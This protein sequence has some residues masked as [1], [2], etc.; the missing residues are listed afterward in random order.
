MLRGAFLIMQLASSCSEQALRHLNADARQ[1]PAIAVQPDQLVFSGVQLEQT[2]SDVLIIQNDGNATLSVRSLSL[3]GSVSFA[4]EGTAGLSIP[5]GSQHRLLVFY[6]ATADGERGQLLISSND[7]EA[8]EIQVPLTGNGAQPMLQFEPNPT[9]FPWS[10]PGMMSDAVVTLS[11]VGLAEL[12]VDALLVSGEGFT[13][14]GDLDLPQHLEPGGQLG[15]P[16]T[17]QAIEDGFAEGLISVES[18]AVPAFMT[19]VLVGRVASG[20]VLGQICT[21]DG[22]GWAVNARVYLPIDYNDDGMVDDEL[23]T[24][25]DQEGRFTLDHVPDGSHTLLV[26]KGSFT[27]SVPVTV[28]GT[29]ELK[30]PTCLDP[31][32]VSIAVVYGEYDQVQE[33]ITALGLPFDGYSGAEL[34]TLLFDPERLSLYDIIFFNCGAGYSWLS[35]REAV[36]ANLLQ[37]V[38]EGGSIYASDWAHQFIEAP[39]P[40]LIDFYGEDNLFVD[41]VV[42]QGDLSRVP[43]IGMAGSING[44]VL[45]ETMQLRLGGGAQLQY[46]LDAWV[47][48][49]NTRAATT[50]LI[51]GDAPV[52]DLTT[53]APAGVLKDVPLATR[54]HVGEGVVIYTSFHNEQQMTRDMEIALKEII[55]SL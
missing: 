55:L 10:Q 24:W 3:D 19:G 49:L 26:E 22:E 20:S 30:E 7:P 9:L 6:T 4:L 13:Q 52:L 12:V 35:E 38:E 42:W 45:D 31:D 44:Q 34:H 2:A 51:R 18:N 5:P 50:A 40:R 36:A 1:G 25:T 39:F 8:S 33:L 32:S 17:F 43:H 23:E 28:S 16:M 41:P 29:T 14:D 15:V 21:P 27:A 47:V 46:D 54:S 48:P 37:Y 11:N 53:G